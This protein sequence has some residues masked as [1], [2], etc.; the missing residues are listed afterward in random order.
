MLGLSLPEKPWELEEPWWSR[1]SQ[2]GWGRA[3]PRK[4]GQKRLGWEERLWRKGASCRGE[5]VWGA[6]GCRSEGWH[7]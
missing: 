6:Q 1:V 5:A 2:S 3:A 4:V 7:R